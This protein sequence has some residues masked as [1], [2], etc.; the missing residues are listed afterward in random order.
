MQS[1]NPL[2]WQCDLEYSIDLSKICMKR[3]MTEPP[4]SHVDNPCLRSFEDWVV[5]WPLVCLNSSGLL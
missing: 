1:F 5:W 3:I 2:L 4:M